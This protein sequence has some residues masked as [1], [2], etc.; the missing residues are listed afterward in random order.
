MEGKLIFK[1][2]KIYIYFN[3]QVKHPSIKVDREKTQLLWF[4]T[5]AES[6]IVYWIKAEEIVRSNY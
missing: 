6:G 2:W 5:E 3:P 4:I 1:I